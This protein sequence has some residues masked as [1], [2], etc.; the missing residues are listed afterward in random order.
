MLIS[1]SNLMIGDI[2]NSP[3]DLKR[4]K[5][6]E[7]KEKTVTLVSLDQKE[8]SERPYEELEPLVIFDDRILKALGFVKRDITINR[9]Q[10]SDYI[11]QLF[12]KDNKF[13]TITVTTAEPGKYQTTI[14]NSNHEQIGKGVFA[15]TH[16]LQNIVRACT[17]LELNININS[18]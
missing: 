5:V 16:E 3:K 2:I 18:L 6:I 4:M 14:S 17:Q 13:F 11:V 12:D 7:I 9:E 1:K 15:S 10:V 8:R